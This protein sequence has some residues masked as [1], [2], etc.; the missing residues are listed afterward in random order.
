VSCYQANAEG[1]ACGVC[2]SCQLRK[3]GFKEAGVADP[4]RY[5]L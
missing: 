3:A 5:Q 4:T 2:E 1:K